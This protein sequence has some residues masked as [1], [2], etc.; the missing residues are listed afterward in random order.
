[1][2]IGLFSSFG[3]CDAPNNALLS[4]SR[5]IC[6]STWQLSPTASAL[7]ATRKPVVPYS[8]TFGGALAHTISGVY[9]RPFLGSCLPLCSLDLDGVL[10]WLNQA[11]VGVCINLGEFCPEKEN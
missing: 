2:P 11:A 3:T 1:M 5:K 6:V 9:S 7:D 4:L 10:F 8:M